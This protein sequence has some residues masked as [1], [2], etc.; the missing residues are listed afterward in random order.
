MERTDQIFIK[1]KLQSSSDAKNQGTEKHEPIRRSNVRGL[2]VMISEKSHEMDIINT[3][4]LKSNQ[5]L[6]DEEDNKTLKYDFTEER[7]ERRSSEE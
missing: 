7:T 6:K 3:K 2:E 5:K 1:N 4:S